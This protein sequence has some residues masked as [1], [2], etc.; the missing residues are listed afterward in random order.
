MKFTEYIKKESLQESIESVSK[1]IDKMVDNNEHNLA[2]IEAS[3]LLKNKKLTAAF[4]GIKAIHEFEREMP[5]GVYEYRYELSKKLNA[6]GNI[7][8]K[9]WNELIRI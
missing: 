5:Q 2:Y 8:F 1:K 7:K 3:K 6:L 4:E 9:N